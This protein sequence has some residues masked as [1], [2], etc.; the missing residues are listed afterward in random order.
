MKNHT[1][2]NIPDFHVCQKVEYLIK[3]NNNK[4]Y[5]VRD[6]YIPR[7]S[8]R[9]VSHPVCVAINRNI[10]VKNKKLESDISCAISK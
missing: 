5:D 10:N 1:K 9:Y 6:M 2:I 4:V 7:K 3:K 8:L